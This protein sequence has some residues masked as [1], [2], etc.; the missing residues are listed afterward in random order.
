MALIYWLVLSKIPLKYYIIYLLR[1]VYVIIPVLMSIV[2]GCSLFL[3]SKRIYC[4]GANL[5]GKMAS[6]LMD[7]DVVLSFSSFSYLST[8]DN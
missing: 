6:D 5:K 3:R 2:R 1:L 7:F 4:C 8:I